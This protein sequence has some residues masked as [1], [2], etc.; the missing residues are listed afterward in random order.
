M[1]LADQKLLSLHHYYNTANASGVSRVA[2][3]S[4]SSPVVAATITSNTRGITNPNVISQLTG[5]VDGFHHRAPAPAIYLP[6]SVIANAQDVTRRREREKQQRVNDLLNT[7]R[8]TK[9]FKKTTTER[10]KA[11]AAVSAAAA[12]SNDKNYHHHYHGG[13]GG[14]A[15]QLM[16]QRQQQQQHSG[17]R[18]PSPQQQRFNKHQCKQWTIKYDELLRYR[19]DQGHW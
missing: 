10:E 19:T 13:G 11:M 5:I 18:P 9:R 14:V 7:T 8:A 2:T 17:L 16:Q 1:T 12:A 3:N 15:Q 6:S 4:T